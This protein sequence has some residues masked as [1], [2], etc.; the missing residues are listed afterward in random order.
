MRYFSTLLQ[1]VCRFLRHHAKLDRHLGTEPLW[2]NL[3][4]LKTRRVFRRTGAKFPAK[5][6][7]PAV[8]PPYNIRVGGARDSIDGSSGGGGGGG[9]GGAQPPRRRGRLWC[10]ICLCVL[11]HIPV[12]E[13]LM[14]WLRMFHWCMVQLEKESGGRRRISRR[15]TELDAAVFQITLEVRRFYRT[16]VW[17]CLGGGIATRRPKTPQETATRSSG[18]CSTL[19]FR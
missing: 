17:F 11:T 14:H 3:S 2:F 18:V 5:P 16:P 7:T 8:V 6:T 10:P 13:G 12:L 4:R 9:K 19:F 15:P 1:T